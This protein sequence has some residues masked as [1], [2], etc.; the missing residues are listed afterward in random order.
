M[1]I[2]LATPYV[3]KFLETIRDYKFKSL[4]YMVIKEIK[5]KNWS[6]E[7]I[8][9]I[10]IENKIERSDFWKSDFDVLLQQKKLPSDWNNENF[11][12]KLFRHT[13]GIV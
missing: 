6:T 9:N 10:Q 2:V 4:L 1:R 12:K 8:W 11:A 13:V 5:N 3:Q 7:E